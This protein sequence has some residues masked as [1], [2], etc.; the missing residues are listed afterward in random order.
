MGAMVAH[1]VIANSR[2][3][4]TSEAI[5]RIATDGVALIVFIIDGDFAVRQSIAW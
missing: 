2:E 1:E 4:V 5:T 3:Y